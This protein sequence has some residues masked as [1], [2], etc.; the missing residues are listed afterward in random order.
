MNRTS[1]E[2]AALIAALNKVSEGTADA[3]IAMTKLGS[4]YR[5]AS[6]SVAI[7][8]SATKAAHHEARLVALAMDDKK[9]VNAIM[10]GYLAGLG[11][12]AR[13][14]PVDDAVHLQIVSTDGDVVASQ[15]CEKGDSLDAITI[16]L[17]EGLVSGGREFDRD[18]AIR[19]RLLASGMFN[20]EQARYALAI[21]PA[22]RRA[23]FLTCPAHLL[24]NFTARATPS[25]SE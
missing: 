11:L 8:A 21:P 10:Q 14:A 20:E 18:Q 19:T 1:K 17:C 25:F 4:A 15:R 3:R 24:I 6:K 9:Q 13:P 16:K 5:E 22:L 2:A 23:D 7:L 12:T